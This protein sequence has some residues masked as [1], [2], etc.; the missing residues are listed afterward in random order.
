[1]VEMTKEREPL[2]GDI[3]LTTKLQ[4]TTASRGKGSRSKSF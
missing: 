4:G 3:E 1:M 2:L